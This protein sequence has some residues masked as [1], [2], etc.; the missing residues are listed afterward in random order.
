M[1]LLPDYR[2]VIE[3]ICRSRE[4]LVGPATEWINVLAI[5]VKLS[6]DEMGGGVPTGLNTITTRAVVASVA[7]D[8]DIAPA[9]AESYRADGKCRVSAVTLRVQVDQ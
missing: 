3:E 8:S 9:D 7:T 5:Q 6:V 4:L 2:H 1:A